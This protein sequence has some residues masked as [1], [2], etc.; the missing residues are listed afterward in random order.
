[1]HVAG[2]RF[3]TTR[4]SESVIHRRAGPGIPGEES[5][6]RGTSAAPGCGSY[7]SASLSA[8]VVSD[9]DREVAERQTDYHADR[10]NDSAC[11]RGVHQHHA[12]ID[13]A[14]KRRHSTHDAGA[15]Q[16]VDVVGQDLPAV[17]RRDQAEQE[18]GEEIGDQD[19]QG[20]TVDR[21]GT[22]NMVNSRS[23]APRPPP[24]I[25][26]MTKLTTADL[27]SAARGRVQSRP[28]QN[29]AYCGGSSEIGPPSSRRGGATSRGLGR[30]V[31]D[32]RMGGGP[33]KSGMP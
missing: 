14:R 25:T 3:Y 19:V 21:F 5:A 24:T 12:A 11:Y 33:S 32:R 9:N 17:Q 23:I 18:S 16:H 2:G 29:S 7:R 4:A 22:I 8:E 10:R 6:E 31:A 27:L 28:R 30:A 20:E 26:S 13:K 15:E 1:M